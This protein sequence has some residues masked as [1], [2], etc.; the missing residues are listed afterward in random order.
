MEKNTVWAIVL[1]ALV[2]LG[3]MFI[4][5]K[6]FPAVQPA[7]AVAQTEQTV[8]SDGTVPV[9]NTAET[10]SSFEVSTETAVD[11]NIPEENF[12]IQTQKVK[13][14]LT[15]RGGDII[16]Y[17]LM[18]H[19]DGD[20]GVQMADSISKA[21]RAF[22]LSFGGY[23]AP[24]IDDV[25]SVKKIDDLTYGFYKKFT[26]KNSDGSSN[27]FTLIKQY[28]FNENDYLFKL[29]VM[30]DGEEGMKGLDFNN[31][32]YTLR[33]SPQI[34]PHYDKKQNRYETR[35]FMSYTDSKRKKQNLNENSTKEYNK[36]YTWTGVGGKY[37]AILVAPV[38]PA[39]MGS[40]FYST[41]IEQGDYANAQVLLTRDPINQKSIQD[42]YYIYIGP[43]TEKSLKI[44]NASTD[45]E[46]NLSGLKLDDS[47]E[48]TGLL[49]W[50][51]VLMKWCMEFFYKLVK[52][53]GV[54][55]ILM[56]ILLKIVLY[57]LTKKSSVSTL[58]M[59][60]LQPQIKEI[61]DKYKAAP[62]KMNVE[63]AK[64]YK[65]TGYNPLMGCLPL[66]IQF[67]IIIAMFNLFNNYFEFRGAMFIPGWIP[68]LSAPDSIY[69]LK[70]SIPFLGNHIR[71]MPVIYLISQLFFG[72]VTQMNPSAGASAAQTKIITL[73]M[74]FLFFFMFYNSP[75]GLIIYWT[76]SN[77][78]QLVQQ[79]AINKMMHAKKT[80]L[81]LNK[82]PEKPV[83]TAK[84]KK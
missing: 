63:M 13:V 75:S 77:L 3:F 35:T 1:S 31:T 15:N 28:T 76:V 8:Q 5:T 54:S 38:Q 71:I 56:T 59:Q 58:K 40:V 9:I 45:N 11:Q 73:A 50:L 6:F 34:G 64:L 74:P 83:F 80:E 16:G 72:K 81:A 14:T 29:D 36:D 84:K 55:I 7:D 25:F 21:N 52:N 23:K 82:A 20:A 51:E 10:A 47:L 19:K 41:A 2:L 61:Q 67:P 18:D 44:Y 46:W 57:P 62:E 69:M 66:L 39:Y 22:S 4:Q 32:A 68:D 24:I 65:E 42:T 70:F 48:S 78:L 37:F 30:I 43:R 79:F 17:E 49:S 53:W 26:V 27:T 33:T 60:E 12:V